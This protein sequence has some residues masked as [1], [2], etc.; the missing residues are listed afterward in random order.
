MS[1]HA[2]IIAVKSATLKAADLAAALGYS[3]PTGEVDFESATSSMFE[4]A[5]FADHSGWIVGTN[6]MFW[7]DQGFIGGRLAEIAGVD[8]VIAIMAEG[9]SDT[10]VFDYVRDGALARHIVVHEGQVVEESGD[11]TP[12]EAEADKTSTIS[13]DGE[14]HVLAIVWAAVSPLDD[15]FG[16]KLSAYE[17]SMDDFDPSM[18]A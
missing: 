6:G 4:G 9:T 1:W 3:D 5:A 16:L 7:A 2:S 12:L 8:E 10:Y 13:E 11:K 17:I 15:L 18:F 14:G